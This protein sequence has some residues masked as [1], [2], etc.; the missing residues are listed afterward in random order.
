MEIT[1]EQRKPGL[2]NPL[3][4]KQV[5]I[6][7]K[8][9]GAFCPPSAEEIQKVAEELLPQGANEQELINRLADFV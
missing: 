4:P 9:W 3:T 1:Q 8:G 6:F 2:K 5:G 7:Q